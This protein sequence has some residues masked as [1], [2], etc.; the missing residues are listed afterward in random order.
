MLFC[1][2]TEKLIRAVVAVMFETE[3]FEIIGAEKPCMQ[4]VKNNVKRN[5][6]NF[7]F[8]D[9]VLKVIMQK[10]SYFFDLIFNFCETTLFFHEIY[11]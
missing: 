1:A 5:K 4:N 9:F 2:L 6:C 7:V 8:M 10:C 3:T 11:N